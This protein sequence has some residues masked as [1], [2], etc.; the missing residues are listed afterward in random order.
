MAVMTFRRVEKKYML[1][2]AAYH[3]FME[4]ISSYM[5]EDEYGLSSICNLYYDT[6]NYELVRRSIEKPVYKEK[7][8]LRSYGVP[9]PGDDVFLEL[10]K[11]YDGVVYK[12]RVELPLE[13]AYRSIAERKLTH[14]G[15]IEAEIT[16]FLNQ[17]ELAPRVF[18]AY[19]RI[20]MLGKADR[21]L[22]VTFDFRI[23]SRVRD[24]DLEDGD[25][26]E[27]LFDDDRVLMEIKASGS[28]PF[29]LVHALERCGIYPISFSKYGMVYKK[30]LFSEYIKE[31]D[32]ALEF[33]QA[34]R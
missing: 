12:R 9:A 10:K 11:K 20:A 7:M 30:Y 29:W 5:Q 6:E 16:Y 1:D 3:R 15:Q 33:F 32:D 2:S 18:L 4:I 19:D 13:E 28:Y 25:A 14:E 34:D 21:D 27:M 23:R 8:R 24:I 26:G 31:H 17:Y 22:R